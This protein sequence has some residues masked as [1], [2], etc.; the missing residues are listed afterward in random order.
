MIKFSWKKI[1]DKLD[2]NA[3]SVLEYFYLKQNIKPPHFIARK[4]PKKVVELSKL[5][6]YSGVCYLINPNDALENATDSW[7]LYMYLELASKRNIFD[8]QTRGIKTLP[9]ALVPE[10][11]RHS[12]AFNTMLEINEEKVIFKYE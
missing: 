11:M 1:N 6:Y 5:P 8:Y 2:W 12:I 9:L 3:M 7:Y 10:Y 4:I